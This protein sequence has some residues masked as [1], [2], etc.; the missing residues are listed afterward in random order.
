MITHD[1]DVPAFRYPRNPPGLD[2]HSIYIGVYIWR[3]LCVMV[4]Q[5]HHTDQ[6]A[7]ARRE[8]IAQEH[9]P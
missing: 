1:D 6:G 9:K 7:A 5:P 4:Q 2:W 3:A 8:R